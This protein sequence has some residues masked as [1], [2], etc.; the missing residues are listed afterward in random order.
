MPADLTQDILNS[1]VITL[2][3]RAIPNP[4]LI[5]DTAAN[6]SDKTLTVDSNEIWEVLSLW[7]EYSTSAT[8]GTRTVALLITDASD[9]IICS[10][11]GNHTITTGE[12]HKLLWAPGLERSDSENAL[13]I[14]YYPFHPK[15][16]PPGYKIRVYDTNAVDTDGD[17]MIIHLMVNRY[18]V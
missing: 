13:G 15:Y 8:G 1:D 16:L 11:T 5:S 7:V 3:T 18:D 9:D 10:L 6:D 17:D 14:V 12:S 4:E 2:L